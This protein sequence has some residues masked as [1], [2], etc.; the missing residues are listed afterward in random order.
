M[1][2]ATT[3]SQFAVMKS[4]RSEKAIRI[5]FLIVDYWPRNCTAESSV[6]AIWLIVIIII[7]T[8]SGG[9]FCYS[10]HTSTLWHKPLK[11]RYASCSLLV[12]VSVFA[13]KQMSTKC[14]FSFICLLSSCGALSVFHFNALV[15]VLHAVERTFQKPHNAKR[16]AH[17]TQTLYS[18]FISQDDGDQTLTRSF[19]HSF[20][21]VLNPTSLLD[22]CFNAI[23]LC[24]RED[25]KHHNFLLLS[26][27]V[28]LPASSPQP[29]EQTIIRINKIQQQDPTN[30]HTMSN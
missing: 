21:P 10:N 7:I 14:N 27:V 11:N 2:Q 16:E 9:N 5:L 30:E 4:A 25:I 17:G 26:V 3:R 6:I 22:N 20:H 15:L 1:Q 19:F 24:Q 29:K 18:V 8:Q 28:M 13:K 23:H 12:L